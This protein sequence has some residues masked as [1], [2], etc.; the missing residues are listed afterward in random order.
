MGSLP[1]ALL[2][3]KRSGIVCSLDCLV[4]VRQAKENER[5]YHSPIKIV[6]ISRRGALGCPVFVMSAFGTMTIFPLEFPIGKSVS[7]PSGLSFIR[8]NQLTFLAGR[9]PALFIPT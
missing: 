6:C 2:P 9:F 8:T 1:Y 7:L 5:R 4:A 3:T